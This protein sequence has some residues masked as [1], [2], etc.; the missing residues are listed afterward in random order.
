VTFET[1]VEQRF[2]VGDIVCL[3]ESQNT[4]YRSGDIGKVVRIP[5]SGVVEV[6][7]ETTGGD[8][9]PS[10]AFVSA[11]LLEKASILQRLRR[12]IRFGGDL[13]PAEYARRQFEAVREAD[14]RRVR[15]FNVGDNLT[16]MYAGDDW[17]PKPLKIGDNGTVMEIDYAEGTLSVDFG[18]VTGKLHARY[19]HKDGIKDF[20]ET[21]ALRPSLA[22]RLSG[23]FGFDRRRRTSRRIR[24]R[25][26]TGRVARDDESE[27]L[28]L[29]D[30]SRKLLGDDDEDDED[31]EAN[32]KVMEALESLRNFSLKPKE[33]A[34][35]LNEYVIQQNDA[36]KV[37]AVAICDHYNHCR[38]H[39]YSL[40][41]SGDYAKPNILLAG[42]T[43]VGKTYLMR[44]IA[45][46][47]GVPFVKADATKFSETGIVGQDVEDLVRELVSQVG[48]NTT[49]AQYGIIYIDEVDKI[50]SVG[51]GGGVG[52]SGG[53]NK[54]GVQSNLLKL[55]ED[56]DVDIDSPAR[57]NM[58]QQLG[59]KSSGRINTRNILFI[60]SGAFTG[61]DEELKRKKRKNNFG[62]SGAESPESLED[63]VAKSYLKYAKTE[64]FVKF[65]M[66]SE[67]IG[68]LPVR[69]ALDK[70][71]ASDL[72]EILTS[73]KGSVL[74]QFIDNFN[75]YS[76]NMTVNDA[77]LTEIAKLAVAEETGARGL[78]TVL[79]RTLREHKFELPSTSI[80]S[81]ELDNATVSNPSEAL[82]RLLEMFERGPD[83]DDAEAAAAAAADDDDDDDNHRELANP[84]E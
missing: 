6:N 42:P 63:E 2:E 77:A 36:K 23:L 81:F 38:R 15:L 17:I 22:F 21:D 53:M 18:H 60:L 13:D 4:K 71:S 44:T 75:G 57:Q 50:A 76:I 82:A 26:V 16:S 11:E 59:G 39:L 40:D 43:G 31:D 80:R 73:S 37:L 70:L 30:L 3:R 52:Y 58:K 68:R 34:S 12:K 1:I 41:G 14:R 61:L 33:V 48:G 49:L 35:Y 28:S 46:L 27:M 79:E 51:E 62:F 45:K 24:K 9:V 66:E 47:I 29:A 8:R 54:R 5:G 56:T 7:F 64:D 10:S 32:S 25:I 19:A 65:G 20:N 83:G 55:L 69:V 67:L 78:V 84:N 72:K 74:N